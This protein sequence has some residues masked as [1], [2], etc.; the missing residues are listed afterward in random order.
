MSTY[1]PYTRV[2]VTPRTAL[3]GKL[4]TPIKRDRMGSPWENAP[5]DVRRQVYVKRRLHQNSFVYVDINAKILHGTRKWTVTTTCESIGFMVDVGTLMKGQ[6]R[7]RTRIGAPNRPLVAQPHEL[8]QQRAQLRL[9]RQARMQEINFQNAVRRREALEAAAAQRA[10][11]QQAENANIINPGRWLQHVLM[12]QAIPHIA[13]MM[14]P[15]PAPEYEDDESEDESYLYPSPAQRARQRAARQQVQQIPAAPAPAPP[16]APNPINPINQ[17]QT[18][19]ITP[20][21]SICC[22]DDALAATVFVGCGHR[23]A[24]VDC[25]K[26]LRGKC[27]ICR[28]TSRFVTIFD[29]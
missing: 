14:A 6:H 20:I 5:M 3:V 23:C 2:E 17:H 11:E 29:A 1:Y 9:Q 19:A 22:E 24:C 21:C 15:N 26:K 7:E 27:P 16:S 18:A 12:N 13:A 28:K 4:L 25:A 8:E 10:A